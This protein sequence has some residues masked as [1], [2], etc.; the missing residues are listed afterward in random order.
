M[1]TVLEIAT[2]VLLI[3]SEMLL[4]SAALHDIATR[5]VPNWVPLCL[6]MAGICLRI[7]DHTPGWGVIAA[8]VVFAVT[9]L[10]WRRGWMGGADV[11]LFTAS[12]ILVPP[13][14]VCSMVLASSLAGGAL[15]LIYLMLRL[16]VGRLPRGQPVGQPA[17]QPGGPP[18]GRP[19]AFLSRIWRVERRRIRRLESLP[20]ASAIAAGAL[21]ILLTV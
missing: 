11:K 20:Y 17:G 16:F 13:K 1:P 5:T 2:R 19:A 4:I 9:L 14:L 8:C 21:S 7:A 12:A 15:V 10:C 3:S 18:V 6:L